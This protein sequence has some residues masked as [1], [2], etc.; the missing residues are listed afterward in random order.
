VSIEKTFAVARAALNAK[1]VATTSPPVFVDHYLYVDGQLQDDLVPFGSKA[2][3]GYRACLE[4]L[5]AKFPGAQVSSLSVPR[6]SEPPTTL[7]A[8]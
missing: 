3:P 4:L 8:G 7:P 6:G 2:S 5:Q 1:A